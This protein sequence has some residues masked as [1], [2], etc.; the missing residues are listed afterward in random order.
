MRF[1]QRIGKT[2]IRNQIQIEDMSA[3]LRSGLWDA[4]DSIALTD[5][6]SK[7]ISHGSRDA[8]FYRNLWHNFFKQPVDTLDD[9]IPDN[10]KGIR[11]WF[12]KAEWFQVYDFLEFVAES[13]DER[14]KPFCTFCNRVLERELAGY[15]FSG[16]NIVPISDPRDLAAIEHAIDAARKTKLTGVRVH[17]EE[18]AAKLADRKQPDYRNSI[19]ES[20]SAIESLARVIADDP[21]AELG[22]ALKVIEAKLGLHPALKK[23][24]SSL[25]GYTSDEGGI[26]HALMDE[27]KCDQDDAKYM[28]VSCSAFVGYLVAKAVKAGVALNK[29]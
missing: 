4:F 27:G 14:Q 15:R 18:A 9:Y 8:R 26:R 2:P 10:V 16:S 12:F 3:E 7:F 5:H 23:S 13:L 21:Q 29:R 17:L 25:Y 1:S 28:L 11:D 24:F 19:K 22:Q 6:V 20:I